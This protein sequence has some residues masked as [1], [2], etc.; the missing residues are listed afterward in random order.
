[1]AKS[2]R[3][4]RFENVAARRVQKTIDFLDSLANCANRSNYDYDEEDVKKMF[5]AIREAVN[6]SEGAFDKRLGKEGKS[7]FKF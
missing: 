3:R 4:A 5:R 2:L 6:R 1:M 7:G